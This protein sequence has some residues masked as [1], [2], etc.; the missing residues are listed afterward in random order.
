MPLLFCSGI[1]ETLEP[2]GH[3]A[4]PPEKSPFRCAG[5]NTVGFPPFSF[6]PEVSGSLARFPWYEKKKK[7]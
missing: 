5:V 1:G 2:N 7:V 3:P 6:K 4:V